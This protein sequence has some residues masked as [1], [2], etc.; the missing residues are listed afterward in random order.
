MG[1]CEKT[2]F[3]F[4]GKTSDV[5]PFDLSVGVEVKKSIEVSVF[6][7]LVTRLMKTDRS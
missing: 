3:D 2:S 1:L 4:K 5:L 7:L 6:W